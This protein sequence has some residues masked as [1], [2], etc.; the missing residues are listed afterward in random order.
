MRKAT[1]NLKALQHNY[2]QIKRMAP[3]SRIM[4]MVKSNAYG[5]GIVP[6]S[7]ALSPADALGVACLS[8]AI[9]LR[10]AGIGQPIVLIS[11]FHHPGELS[12]LNEYCL[13][14][15]V[16]HPDQVEALKQY[17]FE[18]SPQI[19]LKINTGMNRLGFLPDQVEKAFETLS[20]L[21]WLERPINW[22][23]HFANSDKAGAQSNHQQLTLFNQIVQP[24]PGEKTACNSGA[25]VNLPEAHLDWVRPGIMLYGISPFSEKSGRDLG[26]K[27]VMTLEAKLLSVYHLK[28]GDS[29][30]YGSIWSCPENMPVGVISFGYGDGY[31]R[32]GGAQG[33]K[34]SINGVL[35]PLIGRVSMDLMT[36]DLRP[37]LNARVGD[38]VLIW[39][40]ALPVEE[41][42]ATV[43]TIGYELVCRVSSRVE[44]QYGYN[45]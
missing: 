33:A 45:T 35:C 34:V 39:G 42:A 30:G 36:V 11:G 43:N 14:F 13:D 27:P 9:K 15:V 5:H 20:S 3:H 23:T 40:E 10:Q 32:I 21:P 6:V 1:I 19:W 24:F 41:T 28:Q 25:I 16:H 31:P 44:F 29:V 2:A 7:L 18:Y 4:A 17:Q 26:L 37:C 8:E 22:M 12:A 38:T